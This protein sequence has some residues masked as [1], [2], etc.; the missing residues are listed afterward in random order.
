M[1]THEEF[2]QLFDQHVDDVA[3]FLYSYA[4]GKAQLK[5]WVQEVFVKLWESR[6]QI[7]FDHPG[8]KSYLFTTAR[9]HALK[10]L[11]QEKRYEEWLDRH[12]VRLTELHGKD[13]APDVNLSAIKKIHQSALPQISERARKAYLLSREDGLTYPEIAEIMGVSVKTVEA[14]ISKA[15]QILRSAFKDY[16]PE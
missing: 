2:E 5:D 8:F 15:L 10:K 11:H 14:H 9:N 16:S 12:L 13:D 4:A 1:L 7:D 3:A 6:D